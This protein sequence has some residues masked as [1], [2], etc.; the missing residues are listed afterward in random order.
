VRA[1]L[2]ALLVLP[3]LASAQGEAD[4]QAARALIAQRD[5]GGL[6]TAL[7]SWKFDGARELPPAV[8]ALIVEH[9]GDPVAQRPLLSLVARDLDRFERYPKYR[10][11]P[12]FD[13]LHAE[14]KAR[15]DTHHYA[16]KV[17]ATTLPVEA[18]L[19]ALL[20]QLDPA[21]ANEIVMF[22]GERR[23]APA[24]PALQALHSRV[25]HERNTNQMIERVNWAYMQIGTPQATAALLARV[26]ALGAMRTEA[27]G[28]EI[29]HVLMDAARQQT[30]SYPELASALP[31]ELNDNQWSA[32]IQLVAKRR[33]KAGIPDLARAAAQSRKADEAVGAV[34]AIGEADDWR[35]VRAALA[36]SPLS[37]EQ[38]AP[39]ERR[40]DT[41]LADTGRYVAD[42]DRAEKERGHAE[43]KGRIAALRATDPKRYAAEMR[44]LL[45]KAAP[46]PALAQDYLA[47][48]AFQ[49]FTLRQPDDAVASYAAASRL[50]QAGSLDLAAAAAADVYRFDKRDSAKAIEHYRSTL[51][52]YRPSPQ[53]RDAEFFTA[54]RTWIE[55]EVD[56]L[57][58]GRRFSGTVGPRD[59]EMAYLW[60]AMAANHAPLQVPPD[61]GA[62]ER[63][64]ASQYQLGRAFPAMLALAPREMLAF[65]ERHDPAGYLTASV[66]AFAVHKEP[67]P[68]VKAA[69]DTFF[70]SRGIKSAL[71]APGDARFASP[72]K[73]WA[74]FIAASKK[75]DGSAMLQCF[76]LGMQARMEPLFRQLSP[77]QLREMGAS[78]IGFSMAE[79][80]GAMV[81]DATVVRQAKE[82]RMAG[83]VSF[84]NEGGSWKIDSM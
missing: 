83:M 47:L 12:L 6:F 74:T 76:T 5:Q 77:A 65:F 68:Y 63:L 26:R 4:I 39:L 79:G 32:L 82:R 70:K 19:T 20:A 51:A 64:P 52:S 3:C 34:L 7:R 22:L 73:T 15:K 17:I 58:K 57:E 41:A 80:S 21:A 29:S 30:P 45:E 61:P 54:F 55:R 27:A 13:R 46:S 43:Q 78:F 28:W 23:Y 9:F 48:A 2:A 67:S 33:E 50:R 84:L 56:F 31:A 18:E 66:L 14:L 53:S 72:E 59:M 69:A 71:S 60:L 16:I 8:E 49:R 37:R 42:R 1:L 10:S 11:R 35:A 62:L 25:P 40:L 36:K 81:R 38:V 75:G 24:V 44:A